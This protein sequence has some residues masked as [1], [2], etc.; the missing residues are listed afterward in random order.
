MQLAADLVGADLALDLALDR[1]EAT[2][3]PADPQPGGARGARQAL[4]AEHHQGHQ[5]DQQ[6]FGKA[7]VEHDSAKL[8]HPRVRQSFFAGSSTLRTSPWM[9]LPLGSST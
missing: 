7:Y 2:F 1:G 6:Q 3:E 4:G 8:R 5:G 9:V